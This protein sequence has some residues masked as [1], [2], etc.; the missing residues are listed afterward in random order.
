MMTV[1]SILIAL[2]ALVMA[3]AEASVPGH[4]DTSTTVRFRA[5]GDSANYSGRISGD[6]TARYFIDA[7]AGQEMRVALRADN[8]ATYFNVLP[9]GSQQAIFIGSTEGNRFNGRLPG[10]GRYVIEVYLMRAA[11]RRNEASN[12]TV[13]IAIPAASGNAGAGGDY[14]DG[15]AG[16]PDRWMVTGVPAGDRLSVR[17]SPSAGAALVGRLRNGEVVRNLGCRSIDGSRWCRVSALGEGGV[18][19][20]ANGRFLSEASGSGNVQGGYEESSG[21][22]GEVRDTK[23]KESP[24]D[25][26]RKA[27]SKCNGAFRT[28]RSES[29]AGGLLDDTI[30]G[31]VTWYYL[32]YQC[33]FSDGRMPRFPF[34]GAEYQQDYGGD[35]NFPERGNVNEHA[36]RDACRSAAA[37]AF[38]QRAKH[39]DVQPVERT[40]EGYSVY[41]NF[42]QD[43]MNA[44]SFV[45]TFN[46][47]GN[48]RHVYRN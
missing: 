25:C 31:P 6:G 41:G 48:F 9:A 24:R 33:G 45:C 3:L 28:L 27:E 44:G 19:G 20:W 29:H 7:R 38:N 18:R 1:R 2:A 40:G 17:A 32:E 35:T 5:G 21:A 30:P 39:V 26:I 37:M 23:C 10:T 8:G 34:R 36:M 47:S 16:G 14:A 22:D 42:R 11:A 43:G 46:M 13:D 15:D 4:A 12:F